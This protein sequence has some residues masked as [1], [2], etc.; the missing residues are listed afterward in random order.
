MAIKWFVEHLLFINDNNKVGYTECE[1]P[2]FHRH[3]VMNGNARNLNIGRM[4]HTRPHELTR[5]LT[6][7]HNTN[8]MYPLWVFN[9][10]SK[11]VGYIPYQFHGTNDVFWNDDSKL[12]DW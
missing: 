8:A 9:L 6:T 3:T 5:F 11:W 4:F 12:E 2:V 1:A 10:A 7:W